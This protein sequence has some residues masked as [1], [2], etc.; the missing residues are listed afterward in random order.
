MRSPVGAL[1]A[2]FVNRAPAPV[3]PQHLGGS[4]SMNMFSRSQYDDERLMGTYGAVGVLFAIVSRTSQATAAAEWK[5][6]RKAPSG[7]KEDRKEVT[8]H[9]ALDLWNQ[10]NAFMPRQ[11]F[12]ETFQQHVEL[13]GETDWLIGRFGN[14]SIPAELWP[15]R[16]DRVEP[17]PDPFEFI[18][19][20]VYTGPEGQKVPLGV[21]DVIQLKMPNPLDLYRGLGPVQ[22]VLTDLDSARYSAEWNKNFFLNSAQPGGIIEV[23]KRL[24][25]DEFDEMSMRWE[26]QHRGIS[27][28]HRVAIVEQGKWVDRKYTMKDM[29]FAELSSLSDDKIRLAFGYPKAM[30]G[31]TEDVNR[32]NAE[33]GEYLFA[34]WLIVPR[35]DRI[36][37]TLNNDLLPMFGTLGEG[38]EFDYESPVSENSDQENAALTA[39]ANAAVAL[40][41]AG[42][43]D[44]A[45]LAAVNLP[46]M[47]YQKPEPKVIQAPGLPGKDGGK[48]GEKVAPPPK[49]AMPEYEAAMKW[50]AVEC[51]DDSTC[52]ACKANDGKLY[53]N[54]EDA[55]KDYPNGVG[56]VDCVG[57]EFGNKC[58]GK[59]VKRSEDD[60]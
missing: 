57:A 7:L 28:A 40:V 46:P 44:V 2:A 39:R 31:S 8:R 19:G 41:G 49:N 4:L 60:E 14:L 29:Q 27:K 11:E 56:F 23:E 12:V 6:W 32:A 48:P 18:K 15:V 13:T 50:K 5:L 54:R 20:Y 10:P 33:A 1:L 30:L 17:V 55:Y 53:R 38:L 21:K 42:W 37:G 25:D 43:D 9:A 58:R 51:N 59:V 24:S 3:G 16:P 26:E 35:L 45:V 36:K 47:A 52:A 34:R 22:S